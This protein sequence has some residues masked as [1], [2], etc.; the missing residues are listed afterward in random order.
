MK[1]A[2]IQLDGF[3]LIEVVEE[4]PIEI[5]GFAQ[6]TLDDL[7]QIAHML[8]EYAG[9]AYWPVEYV[10]RSEAEEIVVDSARQVVVLKTLKTYVPVYKDIRIAAPTR[11]FTP[12][13]YTDAP[14]PNVIIASVGNVYTRM[15]VFEKV[16]DVME[17]HSHTYDHP[18]LL[19]VGKVE[20]DYEGATTIFEAPTVIYIQA[21]IAHKLTALENNTVAFC[22][23]ALRDNEGN[24]LSPDMIPNGVDPLTLDIVQ[25]L[26]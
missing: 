17:G 15:M 2:K 16:G 18:T 5:D 13:P 8:P 1:Y 20:V 3:A 24:I 14:K 6:E 22:I 7:T 19:A 21:G 9:V 26:G 11:G 25:P 23:H 10:Y 12:I 4:L